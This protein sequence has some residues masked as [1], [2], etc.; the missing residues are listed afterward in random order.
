MA[1]A[2][3]DLKTA[4]GSGARTTKYKVN[5]NTPNN[6]GTIDTLCKSAA[7]PQVTI[8]QIEIWSQ[9]RKAMLQGETEFDNTWDVTFYETEDHSLR[10][11]FI[12]WMK[13]IDDTQTNTHV[14]ETEMKIAK[15]FQLDGSGNETAEYEFTNLWPQVVSTTEMSDDSVNAIGEFTVTFSFDY[16]EQNTVTSA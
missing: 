13:A 4:L 14:N 10:T 11:E 9:G 12:A 6:I 3:S 1:N 8:G 5:I 16:W 15:V 7:F 2:I